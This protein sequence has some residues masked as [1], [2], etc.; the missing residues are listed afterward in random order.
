MLDN[1]QI[2]IFFFS[3]LLDVLDLLSLGQQ[4][5]LVLGPES[6]EFSLEPAD[7]G[8]VVI[9]GLHLL[10]VADGQVIHL[11]AEIVNLDGELVALAGL[12][13]ELVLGVVELMLKLGLGLGQVGVAAVELVEAALKLTVLGSQAGFEG[14]QVLV[15]TAQVVDLSAETT[16]LILE[17]LS[18]GVG[19]LGG[20]VGGVE[21]GGKT[22]DLE[23]EGL[24][25]LL[26]PEKRKSCRDIMQNKM[27]R[28]NLT[29]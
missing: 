11:D 4:L 20:L 24:L 9:V 10:L 27:S 15:L 5:L 3:Y 26:G 22:V 6:A 23:D 14:V 19:V 1:L 12:V 25:L 17:T 18:L 8:L 13:V 28:T 7:G 29:N 16:E 2:L 21:A